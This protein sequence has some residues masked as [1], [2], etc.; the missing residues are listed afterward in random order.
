MIKAKK[1]ALY[2]VRKIQ[3]CLQSLCVLLFLCNYQVVVLQDHVVGLCL[4]TQA[5]QADDVGV[6]QLGEHFSFTAEVELELFVSG[7]QALHQHHCLLL[8]LL[9]ALSFA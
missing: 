5:Q 9:D 1:R 2:Q 4:P 8:A 6:T 3:K 7:L